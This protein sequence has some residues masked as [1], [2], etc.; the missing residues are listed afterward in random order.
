MPSIPYLSSLAAT[1]LLLSASASQAK[2]SAP[3]KY[4]F[5]TTCLP[6]PL[7]PSSFNLTTT[8]S[9]AP[10]SG[11]PPPWHPFTA[12]PYCLP[13]TDYCIFTHAGFH[14]S[15]RGL[16]VIDV[17][18][19]AITT[20]DTVVDNDDEVSRTAVT[21]VADML[22]SASLSGALEPL[23]DLFSPE[24]A[25]S[26]SSSSSSATTTTTAEKTTRE[27]TSEEPD[28]KNLPY[29]LRDLPNKGKGLIA[30]RPIPRGRIFMID[31]PAV[32]ADTKLPRHVKQAQGRELMAEAIGRLSTRGRE[33]VLGLARQ[34]EDEE[35]KKRV[36][37][38]EDV[39][40]TN[41]FV[42]EVQGREY[43]ALFPKIAR[44]NHACKPSAVTRFNSTTLSNT[45]MAFRDI[46]P[47]EEI[48]ISYSTFGLPS[49]IRQQNL[50]SGW[51]FTCTCD[52]CT[53]PPADLAAS[54][55]RREK[56]S[57]L[58]QEVIELV[59]R[60]RKEDMQQAVALYSEA[61]EAVDE[62]GLV[63]HLGGHYEV[64]G[65]LWGAA[66]EVEKGREWAQRGREETEMFERAA[67]G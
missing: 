22:V 18:P 67:M 55:K 41:S 56:V 1:S 59:S 42:V 2:A 62:E 10:S 31:Y 36:P 54:D 15:D 7:Q 33:E 53:S 4:L 27:P 60:G 30:T 16:S 14:G 45:A 17:R 11:D 26:S 32:L 20:E 61:V 51:G 43:M 65:R 25:S 38:S 57:R 37:V 49:T 23:P 64:L 12:R 6:G 40:K 48:T 35:R 19:Y 28:S 63:P 9:C 8:P 58:G 52:L 47:G 39:M 5:G 24:A 44:M 46:L 13:K 50:L 21:A 34:N 66:G 29:E 3:P